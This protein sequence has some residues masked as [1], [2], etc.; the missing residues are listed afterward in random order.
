MKHRLVCVVLF[1][2]LPL[3]GCSSDGSGPG[4]DILS[5]VLGGGS[6]LNQDTIIA[7]LKQA[8]EVGSQK[9]VGQLSSPGGYL[10]NPDLRI[11]LPG[12]LDDVAKTLRSIGM[13]GQLDVLEEKMN[14]AAEQAANEATPVF[15]DAIRQMTF[16]D[17]RK[18]LKGNKTAATD[19]FRDKTRSNLVQRYAPIVDDHMNQVGAVSKYN[20][21]I[22]RYNALPLVP[23]TDFSPQQY[24]TGKAIDGL[25]SVLA[26][27][28][29]DIRKNPAARTTALLRQV[30]GK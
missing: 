4:M 18:I 27:V 28:E 7:G 8:L 1:V 30:F 13:G 29:V 22:G 14:Q 6:S 16:A 11:G 20:D 5:S 3:T 9:A 19:Y 12:K 25:F 17:A 23:K 10:N 26:D 2:C 15:L 24:V 21:V